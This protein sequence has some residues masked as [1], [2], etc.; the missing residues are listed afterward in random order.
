MKA[1]A[2]ESDLDSSLLTSFKLTSSQESPHQSVVVKKSLTELNENQEPLLKSNSKPGT[3]ESGTAYK[4]LDSKLNQK[5]TS[6]TGG[7][8]IDSDMQTPLDKNTKPPLKV[9]TRPWGDETNAEPEEIVKIVRQQTFSLK[10]VPDYKRYVKE[11]TEW[12]AEHTQILKDLDTEH[13]QMLEGT[14]SQYRAND[15]DHNNKV[16]ASIQDKKENTQAFIAS[17]EAFKKDF[18]AKLDAYH[19]WRSVKDKLTPLEKLKVRFYDATEEIRIPMHSIRYNPIYLEKLRKWANSEAE[20]T[21]LTEADLSMHLHSLQHNFPTINER[22]KK[23]N[24]LVKR[25]RTLDENS[26]TPKMQ[27][28]LQELEQK[29]AQQQEELAEM[30]KL[31]NAIVAKW[32]K[33]HNK[34][35]PNAHFNPKKPKS[36]E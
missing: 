30:E 9:Q 3:S 14:H 12:I 19:A 23:L 28:S 1:I 27:A 10:S 29:G 35:A 8:G 18:Q 20:L 16:I 36:R 2:Q 31:F 25:M 15:P 21:G 33:I 11:N 26:I 5:S 24:V 7:K 6:L 34:K 13:A 22:L 17:A 4:H 32:E